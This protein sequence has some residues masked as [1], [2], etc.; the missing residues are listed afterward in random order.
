[1]NGVK[2]EMIKTLLLLTTPS[3]IPLS[4]SLGGPDTELGTYR[5]RNKALLIR[6][7]P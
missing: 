2:V 3:L 5:D 1:M 4:N 7:L 6:L